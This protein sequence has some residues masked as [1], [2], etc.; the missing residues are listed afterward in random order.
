MPE[1]RT[2]IRLLQEN[3]ELTE[4]LKD[5]ETSRDEWRRCYWDIYEERSRLQA[6]LECNDCKL[7]SLHAHEGQANVG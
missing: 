7:K 6:Q 3:K 2:V 5:M 1:M 4:K